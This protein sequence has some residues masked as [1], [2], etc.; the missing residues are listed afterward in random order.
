MRTLKKPSVKMYRPRALILGKDIKMPGDS[1]YVAVPDKYAGK[2]V[3]V[4]FNGM[5]MDIRSWKN[6][7]KLF[8]RFRDQYWTE[9]NNRHQYYTLGYFAW[10]PDR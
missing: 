1:L 6:E 4:I 5:Q 2:P 9:D 3:T 8:R 10:K 7:A